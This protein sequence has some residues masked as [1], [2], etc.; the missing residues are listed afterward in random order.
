M[1]KSA[2]VVKE[3]TISISNRTES[4]QL[5]KVRTVLRLPKQNVQTLQIYEYIDP[6]PKLLIGLYNY[7]CFFIKRRLN[8]WTEPVAVRIRLV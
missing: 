7:H 6:I 8:A 3:V 1:L 4:F 5:R 2:R